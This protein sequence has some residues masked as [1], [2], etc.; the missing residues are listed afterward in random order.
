VENTVAAF[1]FSRGAE[2]EPEDKY[3]RW[4]K[5][6]L[7]YGI[8]PRWCGCAGHHSLAIAQSHFIIEKVNGGGKRDVGSS[9]G[10]CNT[11]EHLVGP[12]QIINWIHVHRN[13]K[14]LLYLLTVFVTTAFFTALIAGVVA[15]LFPKCDN[16]QNFCE[17]VHSGTD[18]EMA[19]IARRVHNALETGRC[20][21][22]CMAMSCQ[23]M[24]DSCWDNIGVCD[25]IANGVCD[26]PWL[27]PLGTD[28]VDC[29]L[30]N[31]TNGTAIGGD[32]AGGI[33]SIGDGIGSIGTDIG[34][35]TGSINATAIGD[36]IGSVGADIGDVI[37]GV[38]TGAIGDGI[39]S[40]GKDVGSWIGAIDTEGIGDGIGAIGTDIGSGI[41]S[42]LETIG[43][44]PTVGTDI[45]DAVGSVGTDLGDAIG[46]V[47]TGS[48]GEGIDSGAGAV[49]DAIGSV[50]T[51][52]IGNGI[53]SIG[54]D[55]GGAVGSVDTGA[56]EDTIGSVAG[57]I[58]AGVGSIGSGVGSALG[59]IIDDA[60]AF[61]NDGQCDEAKVSCPLYSDAADCDEADRRKNI[62]HGFRIFLRD[63]QPALGKIGDLV[64]DDF[65]TL[66]DDIKVVYHCS[67]CSG[68]FSKD[69]YGSASWSG[70]DSGP[71]ATCTPTA[72]DYTTA[73]DICE[74]IA[75]ADNLPD[76][77]E[78]CADG[79]YSDKPPCQ[80]LTWY[81][82]V[83][84]DV[85]IFFTAWSIMGVLSAVV[86]FLRWFVLSRGRIRL[87][88]VG[89]D[90]TRPGHIAEIRLRTEHIDEVPPI[91]FEK[92][93][94]RPVR[95]Q[96]IKQWKR[97]F[98]GYAEELTILRDH[99]AVHTKS[100]FPFCCT[101]CSCLHMEDSYLILLRDVHFLETGREGHR[102]LR[103]SANICL[104]AG[105]AF[106]LSVFLDGIITQ[107]ST[108][109]T[110]NGLFPAEI[111]G[112][113]RWSAV[114]V[115]VLLYLLLN[116]IAGCLKRHYIHLGCFPEEIDRGGRNTFGG[117][118]PFYLRLPLGT[119]LDDFGDFVNMVRAA[120]K[121]SRQYDQVYEQTHGEFSGQVSTFI[122]HLDHHHAVD[123]LLWSVKVRHK[124]AKAVRNWHTA[125][126]LVKD[127]WKASRDENTHPQLAGF[128][129][130][131]KLYI[132]GPNSGLPLGTIMEE[133]SKILDTAHASEASV[134]EASMAGHLIKIGGKGQN[135]L[136]NRHVVVNE[137]GI[138]WN[139]DTKSIGTILR[140]SV[141][142]MVG[143]VDIGSV[144]AWNGSP[145]R[146]DVFG[147]EIQTK[148]HQS[149][150]TSS[151][152][153]RVIRFVADSDDARQSWIRT[154]QGV[155]HD[156][157]EFE[158]QLQ[159]HKDQGDRIELTGELQKMGG[160]HGDKWQCRRVSVDERGISWCKPSDGF[161]EALSGSSVE[162]VP[163]ADVVRV[164]EWYAEDIDYGFEVHTNRK[165][166]KE[167]RFAASSEEARDAWIDVI[168]ITMRHV[169]ED[170]GEYSGR[171]RKL[172]GRKHDKWQLRHVVVNDTGIGWSHEES[173]KQAFVSAQDIVSISE[174]AEE[175]VP[176]GFEM[177]THRKGGKSIRFAAPS[178]E[179]RQ[180]WMAA[181][182]A[183]MTH[184][185]EHAGG[186]KGTLKKRGGRG[187]DK[188][189]IRRV[190]VSSRGLSW[191]RDEKQKEPEL[192][193]ADCVASVCREDFDDV[194]TASFNDENMF[195][196]EVQVIGRKD[197][198]PLCFAAPS[199]E[200]RESWISAITAITP[201][202]RKRLAAVEEQRRWVC[203]S[204]GRHYHFDRK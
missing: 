154:I 156:V 36:G 54:A 19:A 137:D 180:T 77:I 175:N 13:G 96:V 78:W 155:M 176:F 201:H 8:F 37:E 1:L 105:V 76:A 74:S 107:L 99:V 135:K 189:Q 53:G 142:R 51:G 4:R 204:Q 72:A 95:D 102:L 67:G 22:M 143:A 43:V 148:A 159:V 101:P 87:G 198:K 185:V 160:R 48:V 125:A 73:K 86:Q 171:L 9:V 98:C 178:E 52:A 68:D 20:D 61:A 26:E 203:I 124:V 45:A 5:P 27:C 70:S 139:K 88:V 12:V 63:D 138:S 80:C 7:G 133:D 33:T 132:S 123:A 128:G 39:G 151:R 34:S 134:S 122:K 18:S 10:W 197:G 35:A 11:T 79:S 169:V 47:D 49:G 165:G 31:R 181:I 59:G 82:R 200:A 129:H 65:R 30:T 66:C 130:D 115:G 23:D 28:N 89:V 147:F 94:C 3:H 149:D 192:V 174:W 191:S 127:N 179:S 55:I 190:E 103:W 90:Q 44:D 14:S 108:N 162:F 145:P 92:K 118:S 161:M 120:T 157:A 163:S 2:N 21:Q 113:H 170:A 106:H 121:E 41:G 25:S 177:H 114:G 58:G 188:W 60:C 75:E 184:I 202:D 131:E 153:A 91:I 109:D 93:L 111:S 196:F 194:E 64:V 84:P 16:M 57:D 6:I 71:D 199:E 166:G 104:L 46:L 141:K 186:Y 110:L 24:R 112:V 144:C 152:G 126:K 193:I 40:V 85:V 117:S 56:I 136:Q 83:T 29:Q 42:G 97:K 100:S 69:A 168:K 167:L 172:G 173:S 158:E 17:R 15:V 195:G 32:I 164:G 81:D 116:I 140:G 38:D 62:V 119:K 183:T 50:D 150:D 146:D 187:H 182:K